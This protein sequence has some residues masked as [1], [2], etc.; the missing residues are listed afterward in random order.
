[1]TD[2]SGIPLAYAYDMVRLTLSH[3]HPML[4]GPCVINLLGEGDTA[5]T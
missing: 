3:H 4:V 5:F 1:M 2:R